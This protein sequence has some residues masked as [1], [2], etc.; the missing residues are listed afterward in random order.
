MITSKG[1]NMY[2]GAA[3]VP[4]KSPVPKSWSQKI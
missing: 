1:T 4:E 2:A 3:L